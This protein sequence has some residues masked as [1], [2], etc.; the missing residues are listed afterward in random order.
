VR[1]PW[2][3]RAAEPW[4]PAPAATLAVDAPAPPSPMGWAFLPPIQRTLAAPITPVSRPVEF[5]GELSA[6]RSPAF[7]DSL[8]HAVVDTSSGGVIDGDGG[9][10]AHPTN[11]TPHAPELTLLPP[12]RPTAVQRSV[13]P[14]AAA[15][16]PATTS[17]SDQAPM[18]PSLIRAP[19]TGMPLVHR[20]VIDD[21]P[22]DPG[23]APE[24]DPLPV[25][26]PDPVPD[27]MP[28]PVQDSASAPAPVEQSESVPPESVDSAEPSP[29]ADSATPVDQVVPPLG[30]APA[31]APEPL[32]PAG[33][34]ETV[35]RS[36]D[37]PLAPVV[38][39]S[40]AKPVDETRPHLGLGPPLASVPETA[41]SV[42]PPDADHGRPPLSG[43]SSGSSGFTEIPIQRT[44]P[45]PASAP[46]STT[47]P[48]PPGMPP[49]PE[50]TLPTTGDT[51]EPD[52][53]EPTAVEPES[54]ADL[55]PDPPVDSDATTAPSPVAE[56][57]AAAAA[58]SPV[59]TLLSV[60][61][62][63][64][65]GP[66][67][68]IQRSTTLPGP[69]TPTATLVVRPA[70]LIPGPPSRERVVPIQRM[71]A[72]TEPPAPP[73]GRA[74][75]AR[76][77]AQ[78]AGARGTTNPALDLLASGPQH[79]AAAPLV[80]RA[81]D[82]SSTIGLPDALPDAHELEPEPTAF[83]GGSDGAVAGPSILPSDVAAPASGRGRTGPSAAL[84]VTVS[85]AVERPTAPAVTPSIGPA[86]TPSV[87]PSVTPSIAPVPAPG[88]LPL[89]RSAEQPPPAHAAAVAALEPGVVDVSGQGAHWPEASSALD[90]G[91]VVVARAEDPAAA[92]GAVPA[93]VAGSASG[94]APG[95]A[96]RGGEDVEA[97]AQRLFPP[98]LRRLKNE[99][100]LDR[101]RRGMRTDAW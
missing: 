22:P 80:Q 95:G 68:S 50:L 48:N 62:P 47:S 41:V 71:P 51:A 52:E 13:R 72:T 24:P 73:T 57:A 101:E 10:L 36:V 40:S 8:S 63:L 15:P 79:P 23:P 75:S 66:E 3:R 54:P 58:S 34:P 18:T 53:A 65:G 61:L 28:D 93:A 30:Q 74:P 7:T 5:P 100:L 43:E 77:T 12:P 2:T 20:A 81:T 92:N 27:P 6:W 1:W 83:D 98:M 39:S 55:A 29:S 60:P 85:R 32:A 45:P 25:P 14:G 59:P 97:L 46:V 91:Q 96:A 33:R 38:T 76:Q 11:T 82:S 67:T 94:D 35:Q 42:P 86:T 69:G 4:Q 56:S 26:V 21:P 37:T 16:R 84:P 90:T 64:G 17:G 49:Q 70:P 78:I 89:A 99:F 88:V 44:V 87:T 31:P 19:S 9:G